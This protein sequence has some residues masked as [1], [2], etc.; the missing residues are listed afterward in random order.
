LKIFRKEC[1][2]GF[3]ESFRVGKSS[4]G[5]EAFEVVEGKR[6]NIGLQR[7]DFQRK[8]RQ[9]KFSEEKLRN[10]MSRQISQRSRGVTVKA[11]KGS[12]LRRSRT[13]DPSHEGPLDLHADPCIGFLT[14]EVL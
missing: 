14:V 12:K 7:E 11:S 5:F 1:E 3:S 13:V 6:S 8:N 10:P 2:Q 9:S 4:E